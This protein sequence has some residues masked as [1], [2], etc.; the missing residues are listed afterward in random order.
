MLEGLLE[1]D[2]ARRLDAQ[3]TRAA[4]ERVLAT[5]PPAAHPPAPATV[6]A[7]VRGART[8][9]LD[10]RG[11]SGELASAEAAAV[12]YPE[13]TETVPPRPPGRAPGRPRRRVGAPVVAALAVLGLVAAAFV[14]MRPTD[15]T[16][17]ARDPR[18]QA[19]GAD[20]GRGQG[21]TA[22]T[23]AAPEGWVVRRG[24]GWSVAVPAGYAVSTFE[25][26]PQYK[27]AAT[28]RTLRVS[29]TA[30]GGGKADAVR[31]RREQA[32]AFARTHSGYR[33]IE[34]AKA[35]YRGLE[36]A[37]WEF[38][39]TSGGAALHALSRVFVEGGRGYSLFFQTRAGDDWGQARADFERMAA[40]FTS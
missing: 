7:D 8:Q 37:D 34:I 26:A 20:A 29:A 4:L 11:V 14:L 15:A 31:D 36:A 10:L 40:S 9:V 6:R 35:D 3:A 2:P 13:G 12:P 17:T 30:P 32:A 24:D 21:G 25:G 39:Y 19:S 27:D 38:T 33:E 5:T 23:R 16:R 18:G 28:G 1:R 22:G